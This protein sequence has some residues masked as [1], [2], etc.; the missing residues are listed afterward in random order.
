MSKKHKKAG[1]SPGT[2]VY[3]GNKQLEKIYIH[4][5]QYD[6]D[7]FVEDKFDNHKKIAFNNLI[8][9][10]VNWYDIRGI[11]D[12][13]LI[14]IIGKAFQIHP[15]ILEDV[16]D[17]NQRPKF[18]EYELGNFITIRALSFDKSKLSVTTEQISLYFN[19]SVVLTFQENE[20]DLFEEVRIRI[21]NGKG[22]I[23]NRKT[24]YLS[25]AIIDVLIDNYYIVLEEIEEVIEELEE[26]LLS[27]QDL[28]NKNRIHI[29]KKELL[30]V[31]KSILPLREAINRF[32]KNETIYVE[33]RT[34]LFIRDAYD[35]TIQ[36]MDMLDSYRDILTGL[37]DLLITEVS[38][39]M[40]QVMQVLTLVATIFIPLTFLAG[41]YGMNFDNMPELHWEYSYFVLLGIMFVLL[42][43][44]IFYFKKR[45]WL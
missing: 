4:F 37:Q 44:L 30:F 18:D 13:E 20:S 22:R 25:Y 2:I 12:V 35:H 39:K 3:T 10:K 42:V 17:V 8:D 38:Y 26:N 29:L 11:H 14:E 24:D 6:G 28:R 27:T 9:G 7:S 40:N 5:L 1:L 15:L 33:D 45:K 36:I 43:G 41:V 31:R 16:A 34:L 21:K 19:K 23:R 32:S